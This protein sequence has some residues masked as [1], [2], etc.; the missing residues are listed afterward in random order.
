MNDIIKENDE[1]VD[2]IIDEE[3]P[4]EIIENENDEE[5]VPLE[6]VSKDEILDSVKLSDREV[7]EIKKEA[8]DDVKFVHDTVIEDEEETKKLYA[9]FNSFLEVKAEM[10]VD[11]GIKSTIPT[12]FDL[13]DAILGGGFAIGALNIIVGQPGS[14]KSMLAIQAMGGGQRAFKGKLLAAFLDSEQSAT[15][16]RMANLGVKYPKLRPYS[17]ITVEKVFKFIEGLCLFK[18]EKKIIDVPSIVCW[19]SI[20]NTLSQ[21]ERQTDDINS[22]IGYKARLLSILVPKYT[23][24]CANYQISLLAV[25]QLRDQLQISQFAPAKE[26]KFMT[27]GKDMPGG[28][29]LRYNAF[30]LLEMKVK[31][32]LTADKYGF[33]GISCKVKCVK[34]KLFAPNVEIELAGSFVRGFSNFWTNYIFLVSTK[35]LTSGAWNY[36]NSL[37]EKKFRTKDAE[38]LYN[39]DPDFKAAFDETVK[40]AIQIDIIDKYAGDV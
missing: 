36:L 32:V 4:Q 35:R 7:E 11:T 8:I 27:Q 25:N 15:T 29:I 33:D 3:P 6:T 37:P 10:Q 40:E 23:A 19:D 26:L 2:E 1:V 38:S 17:D 16:N 22:V 30:Q 34:N 31:T 28:T 12:G 14:G 24:K 13:L 5:E 21:K 9:E 20:A 18:E 39:T